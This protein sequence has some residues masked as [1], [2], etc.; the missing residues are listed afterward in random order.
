LTWAVV[1]KEYAAGL[2]MS[3]PG[4]AFQFTDYLQRLCHGVWHGKWSQPTCGTGQTLPDSPI[5]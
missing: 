2:E 1:L 3:Y 5:L 4:S